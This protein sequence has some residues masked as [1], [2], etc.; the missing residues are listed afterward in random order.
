MKKNKE[1]RQMEILIRN[2]SILQNRYDMRIADMNEI[3][4]IVVTNEKRW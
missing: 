3:G 1:D 2:A 4:E